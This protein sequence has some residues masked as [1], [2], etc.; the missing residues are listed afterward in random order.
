MFF[1]N[2]NREGGRVKLCP[3]VRD[4]FISPL[5]SWR[6]PSLLAKRR[7]NYANPSN[8]Y[9]LIAQS[10]EQTVLRAE[11]AQVASIFSVHDPR[12][13]NAFAL[14]SKRTNEE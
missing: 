7:I 1:S 12:T 4:I 13:N 6:R 3:T 2:F 14:R 11:K 8:E 5:F 9:T 10:C